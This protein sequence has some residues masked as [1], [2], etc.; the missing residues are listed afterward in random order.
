[1]KHT[2]VTTRLTRVLALAPLLASATPAIAD[3]AI[4]VYIVEEGKTGLVA[5]AARDTGFVLRSLASEFGVEAPKGK[6]SFVQLDVPAATWDAA[7][8]DVAR[9]VSKRGLSAIVA[10]AAPSRGSTWAHGLAFDARHE[11]AVGQSG[12]VEIELVGRDVAELARRVLLDRMATRV[13]EARARKGRGTLPGRPSEGE[14]AIQR[15]G[16]VDIDYGPAG[17][18]IR[19]DCSD[20]RNA[21]EPACQLSPSEGDTDPAPHDEDGLGTPEDLPFSPRDCD[22]FVDASCAG[23]DPC[24]L[25]LAPSHPL[26]DALGCG[27]LENLEDGAIGPR[28]N[29]GEEP[30]YEVSW[31]S[32]V[33][34]E[35]DSH[36]TGFDADTDVCMGGGKIVTDNGERVCSMTCTVI[37]CFLV[38]TED[39]EERYCEATLC[40]DNQCL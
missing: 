5:P 36:C 37:T 39:A 25:G 1:M 38:Q 10:E 34:D 3:D 18:P 17:A 4:R 33:W 15:P 24:S 29:G 27:F 9:I 8:L 12:D 11:L 20:P 6:T 23:G 35:D 19:I 26:A 21:G 32:V 14:G 16:K 7:K 31:E 40:E 22:P 30:T 2:T 13:A 28:T